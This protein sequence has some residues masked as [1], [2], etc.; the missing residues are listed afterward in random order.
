MFAL[1]IVW[2]CVGGRTG[3]LCVIQD[4]A[5]DIDKMRQSLC[6][7]MIRFH[8]FVFAWRLQKCD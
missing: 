2:V 3:T 7:T 8:S 4:I 6:N 1:C 5:T